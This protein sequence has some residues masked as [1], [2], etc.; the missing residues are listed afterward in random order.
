M[1]LETDKTNDNAKSVKL[2]RKIL[3]T[4]RNNM[5]KESIHIVNFGPIK[6]VCIEDIKPFMVFIG[7]S[8]SGKSTIIKLIALFR[9]IY[10][11]MCIRTFL[12]SSGVKNTFKFRFDTYL[13]NNEQDHFVK[14]DTKI[15]YTNGSIKLV[16]TKDGLTGS[17]VSVPSEEIS[18]EKLSFVADKRIVIPDMISNNFSIRKGSFYLTETYSDYLLATD[19]FKSLD[20]PFLNV[21]WEVRK[22]SNSAKHRLISLDEHNPYDIELNE[23]SSGMQTT[24]SLAVIVEYFAK[25]YDLIES[26]NKSILSYASKSD[27]WMTFKAVT[28]LGDF[29]HRRVSLFIE[30]PEL[31]L[32]PNAQDGLMQ[33]IANRCFN[34]PHDY[35]MNVLMTTHSPYIFNFLNVLM[36]ET[37]ESGTHIDSEQVGAY[38]VLNG[39]A[40]SLI[41]SD[42]KG[43][44]LI[45]TSDLTEEMQKIST[46][47]NTLMQS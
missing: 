38:M 30:E 17:N 4:T 43:R 6:D 45:E 21:R 16:F 34:T 2:H 27:N 31:S 9:W 28:N 25:Y 40:S 46:R 15:T 10:K 35:S 32:F 19:K 11:M 36:A 33:F 3:K 5:K 23:A 8:G 18:L 29:K 1:I 14:S 42:M 20:I 13:K 12:K 7:E 44:K 24:T 22:T 47:Y 39:T 26:I 37:S 41:C